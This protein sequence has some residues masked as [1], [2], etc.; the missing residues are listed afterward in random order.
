[1]NAI[2]NRIAPLILI[3]A[4]AISFNRL[5][6]AESHGTALQPSAP[7]AVGMDADKLA[8]IGPRMRQFVADKQ[9]AGAVTFVARSGVVV[10][11]EAVGSADIAHDRPMTTDS[12]FAIASMTKPITA[13]AIM[14]LQDEGKLSV[15]D[16]V[17]KYIPQFKDVRLG[18]HPPAR[19]ITIR[20]LMTHTAGISSPNGKGRGAAT[21]LRETAERIAAEPLQFEP[22][23]KWKYSD[24]ITVCGAIIE[25]VSG[26]PYDEF[27]RE[28]IF[29]PLKMTDTTFFPDTKARLRLATMYHRTKDGELEAVERTF[30]SADPAQRRTPSPSGG[31]YSTASDMARFYQMALGRL[32][33]SANPLDGQLNGPGSHVVSRAAVEQMTRVQTGEIVTGFTPGNGWG[34][35]WCIVRQPQGITRM[36]S[37]GTFGHGGAFGTQGWIDPKRELILVLMVQRNDFGNSDASEVREAFQQLAVAAVR[38]E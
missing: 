30:S 34:L 19:P 18:D 5:R 6:A 24:G 20:D 11:L 37:P 2:Q 26:K 36:L 15:D 17:S 10:H 3:A 28:R 1:M 12:L 21:S 23:S 38:A 16:P 35:G 32:I 14:I 25:A 4:V 9:I 29:E 27:L 13:T 33:H 7:D 8:K 22:G 31:L